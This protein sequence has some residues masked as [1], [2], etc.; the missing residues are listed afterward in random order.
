MSGAA[1]PVC[2]GSSFRFRFHGIGHAYEGCLECRFERMSDPLSPGQLDAHY[3]DERTHGESAWQEHQ[4]N[5]A[6]FDAVLSR[7]EKWVRPGR[8]LDIG[9]SL[10][11]S[12][13]VARARGWDPV[14]LELSRPV[15]EFGRD[16]W[17]LDI[18]SEHLQAAGFADGS[19]DLVWMHHTLEHLP[20][21]DSVLAQCRRL[22]SPH[23]VMYQ[24]LP[25]HGSLK[26]RLFGTCWSYGIT[27]EHL[28]SFSGPTL[29]LMVQRLGFLVLEQW[30]RSYRQDPRLVR[31]LAHRLG[32]LET[33]MRWC[34]RK[35]GQFD[36]A[37]YI[38]F[39]TDNRVA[40]WISNRAWPARLVEWLGLGEDLHLVAGRA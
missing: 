5:M 22:L 38:R 18:R 9:C 14:G 23:G 33:L 20:R 26:S 25:N 27:E 24:S 2:G 36:P 13:V 1:C 34:G 8:F 32:R 31:D 17:G 28:S 4:Q 11:T 16:K 12:L 6:R 30:T 15:A 10:G 21:P 40:N 3:A 19:F 29:R 37:A 35:D 7:L 39:L